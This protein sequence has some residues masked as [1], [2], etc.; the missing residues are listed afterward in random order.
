MFYGDDL[1]FIHI[2][3]NAGTSIVR[4]LLVKHGGGRKTLHNHRL[5]LKKHV[6]AYTAQVRLS[7]RD[8]KKAFKFAVVR[9]PWDRM[10]STWRYGRHQT[11]RKGRIGIL[12]GLPLDEQRRIKNAILTRDFN[13]WLFEFCRKYRWFPAHEFQGQPPLEDGNPPSQCQWFSQHG[14]DLLDKIYRFE[15]LAELEGDLKIRLLHVNQSPLPDG[16]YQSHYDGRSRAWVAEVFAEDI[17][18]FGYKF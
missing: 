2:P 9:N 13:W 8:W 1:L 4:T 11:K 12:D 16:T 15:N 5:G 3:K 7:N 18:R 6:P 14:Y 17:E 10:V